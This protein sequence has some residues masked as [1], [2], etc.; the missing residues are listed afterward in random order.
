[1][2]GL[3][4]GRPPG[5]KPQV[6]YLKPTNFNQGVSGDVFFIWDIKNVKYAVVHYID[7]LTDYHVGAMDFDP[8]SDWAAD[9]LCRLWYDVFGPPDSL[10][11]DGGT[12]FQGCLARLNELFG[13]QHDIVPDQAKWRLGHAE[14]HGS[15]VKTGRNTPLPGSLMAQITS[16]KVKFKLNEAITQEEALRR[17]DRI[18]AAAIEACHWLDAHEGLRRALAARSRPPQYELIRE[19]TAV[20]VYD[21]PVNKRGLARR[22]QDNVSWSGPA[23]VVCVERNGTIPKK[24]WVRLRSRVKAYPL[25]KIRLATADEMISADFIVGAL[26]DLEGELNEGKL[27]VA[28]IEEDEKKEDSVEEKQLGGEV[29]PEVEKKRELTHDVPPA[30]GGGASSPAV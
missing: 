23:I 26:K 16:G 5:S 25:E 17:A 2:S 24:I 13:V 20:Y 22:L 19:G 4:D 30:M 28:D 3:P 8:S 11:T 10:T 14:R 21:P 15:I 6:S 9:V 1:M 27:Q 7:E 18:R 12:E 29:D